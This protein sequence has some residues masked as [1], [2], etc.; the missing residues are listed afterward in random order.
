MTN[1]TALAVLVITVAVVTVYFALSG[2][3]KGCNPDPE[4]TGLDGIIAQHDITARANAAKAEALAATADS[5]RVE[6]ELLVR[7]RE[8][9][10]LTVLRNARREA[11]R[12]SEVADSIFFADPNLETCSDALTACQT[13]RAALLVELDS[14]VA[15]AKNAGA[16]LVLAVAEADTLRLGLS[17]ALVSISEYEE[18]I[19][20]RTIQTAGLRGRVRSLQYQRAGA[21][22]VGAA[23]GYAGA[24]IVGL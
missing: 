1:R 12:R 11:E 22:V 21:F 14:T 13:V 15:F 4:P 23:L 20:L 10:R 8:D 9:F 19:A 7:E 2:G 6:R 5:L 16:Q 17:H 3:V 18:S 24:K